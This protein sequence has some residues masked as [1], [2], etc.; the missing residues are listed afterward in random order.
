MFKI[1]LTVEIKILVDGL[2][3]NR[4]TG[5]ILKE[6]SETLNANGYSNEIIKMEIKRW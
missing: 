3:N 2:M 4:K 6:I 1:K 5:E